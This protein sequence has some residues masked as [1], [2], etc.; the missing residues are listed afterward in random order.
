MSTTKFNELKNLLEEVE[1]DYTKFNE[2][3]VKAAG[4]RIR[5][6]MQ[7]IKKIAQEIRVE[8]SQKKS[9]EV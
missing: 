6:S 3:G 7:E 5:K 2:K 1:S 8:V 9:K 4:V